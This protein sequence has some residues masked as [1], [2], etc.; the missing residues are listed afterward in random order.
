MV[1]GVILLQAFDTGGGSGVETVDIDDVATIPEGTTTSLV[2]ESTTTTAA[3]RNPSEVKVLAVNGTGRDGVAGKVKD[4]LSD[5]GY[6]TLSAATAT[7]NVSRTSIQYAPGYE[8]EA[9]M[10]AELLVPPVNQV[11]PISNP[12]VKEADIRGAHLIVLLGT[13]IPSETTTTT[14]RPGTTSTTRSTTS[15][16]ARST[17]TTR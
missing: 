5:R 15:T 7:S 2:I 4:D 8:S 11:E 13:D 1:L 12:P 14:S 3:P 9:R 16:T 10:L 6:N 17:N